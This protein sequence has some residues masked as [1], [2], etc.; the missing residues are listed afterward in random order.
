MPY[1]HYCVAIFASAL[2]TGISTN[3]GAGSSPGAVGSSANWTAADERRRI[4]WLGGP[5]GPGRPGFGHRK[6]PGGLIRGHPGRR[7]V[8]HTCPH[9]LSAGDVCRP[10]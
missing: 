7:F 5:V 10:A 9:G 3:A 1:L 4:A 8:G 6:A 2:P